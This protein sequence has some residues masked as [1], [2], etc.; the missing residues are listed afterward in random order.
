MCQKYNIIDFVVKNSKLWHEKSWRRQI[1]WGWGEVYTAYS[2]IVK[3]ERFL[4]K[5]YSAL[6]ILEYQ[7]SLPPEVQTEAVWTNEESSEQH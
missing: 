7:A 4:L 2:Q 6:S 1:N 5:C 3:S